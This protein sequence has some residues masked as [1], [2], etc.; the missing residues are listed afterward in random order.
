MIT[1]SLKTGMLLLQSVTSSTIQLMVQNKLFEPSK[2]GFQLFNMKQ[3]S[4]LNNPI[5]LYRLEQC[6]GKSH[7]STLL[8]L[9]VL[10]SCVK[11]CRREFLELV[12]SHEFAEFL[13]SRVISPNIDPGPEVQTKVL[14]LLQSWAHAF[15]HDPK[16]QGK[17]QIFTK[18][19]IHINEL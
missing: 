15:S 6:A 4:L 19:K 10:E 16:L 13:I 9:I 17:D 12:C 11:N 5:F 1:L 8:T 18:N 2:K 7:K 3:N 14:S